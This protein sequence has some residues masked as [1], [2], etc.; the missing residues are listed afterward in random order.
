MFDCFAFPSNSFD[1]PFL[2]CWLQHR[3]PIKK[4]LKSESSLLIISLD[5]ENSI[6]QRFRRQLIVYRRNRSFCLVFFC[7]SR[8]MKS[9]TLLSDKRFWR[10]TVATG[11]KN[12]LFLTTL[13]NALDVSCYKSKAS[14]CIVVQKHNFDKM[15][16]FRL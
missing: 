4:Q 14:D 3:K 12:V 9:I 16:E 7:L 15:F 8:N 1:F 6:E 5:S 11:L 13:H 2:Q 10:L